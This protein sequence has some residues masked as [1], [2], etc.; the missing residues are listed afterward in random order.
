MRIITRQE[1]Q[2][3]VLKSHG[4]R[5]DDHFFDGQELPRPISAHNWITEGSV[6]RERV[7]TS[8]VASTRY[9]LGPQSTIV[10]DD[11]RRVTW[12][13][14]VE[15]PD[16]NARGQQLWLSRFDGSR[17]ET[18]SSPRV[19]RKLVARG[20]IWRYHIALNKFRGEVTVVWV[21]RSTEGSTL[22]LDGTRIETRAE[23]PDFPFF[24]FSQPPIGHVVKEEP[25]FAVLGYKCRRKGQ[26]YLRTVQS[27][28]PGPEMAL[29]T[30]NVVGGISFGVSK[31]QVLARV[32]LLRDGQIV[33]ALL[34]STDA[35]RTF[36]KPEPLDL[37][38]YDPAFRAVP[39]YAEP[40]VDIGGNFHAPIHMASEKESVALNYVVRE[41]AV[42]EAIRVSG[43]HPLV[44]AAAQAPSQVSLEVFPA[45]LGN[46]NGYGTGVT[47]GHG[48]I[49]VLST[50]GRLFSSNSSAGGLFFPESAMLN[51]EMPMVAV[52]DSTECYT[53]GLKPNFVSMDYLFIEADATGRPISSDLH[54]ETWDMPLPLPEAEARSRGSQVEVRVLSDADF[55]PGEVSFRFSDPSIRIRN[56]EVTSL[57]T[58]VIQTD[59]EDLKGK[60][61]IYDVDSLFHRH[62][63]EVVVL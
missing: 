40:I 60:T 14:S 8:A 34:R 39:G 59:A 28:K 58:A 7:L 63:G 21:T 33:P 44:S 38:G 17:K 47:D 56:V 18:A 1:Q 6:H 10:R 57:R 4:T 12:A 42:V 3:Q 61:L 19:E 62:Y 13:A 52:F 22:W 32:D 20:D 23:E 9:F 30:E 16:G 36:S 48:L 43:S 49:M 11:N 54:V 31:D 35:G 29:D 24:V 45:T 50:E 55:E 37:S 5:M 46:P 53:T 15:S 2:A 27:G 26:I 41:G 51:H 25:P